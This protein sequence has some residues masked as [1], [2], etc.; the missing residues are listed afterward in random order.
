MSFTVTHPQFLQKEK[1]HGEG[2]MEFST[3]MK[4]ISTVNFKP[5]LLYF[6]GSQI[7]S[8]CFDVG[9]RLTGTLPPSRLQYVQ[10]L[11]GY[12][13]LNAETGYTFSYGPV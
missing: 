4:Y 3:I 7:S 11:G 2:Y 8:F 6:P 10:R 12:V 1:G 9:A 13:S 5:P